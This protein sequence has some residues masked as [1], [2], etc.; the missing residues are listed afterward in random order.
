VLSAGDSLLMDGVVVRVLAPTA[1]WRKQQENPNESSVVLRVE[2]GRQ[3]WLLTGDAE[4]GAESWLLAHARGELA[5]SVLKV[6]HHGSRSSSTPEF[7]E[8]VSPRVAV[9]SVG[10][11]NDY[12][13]PSVEVLQ[14][15][16]AH[17]VHVLRTDDEGTMILSTD[18]HWLEVRTEW[19]RWR[20]SGG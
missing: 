19:G 14:R 4:A 5:A 1:D 20:Y 17:G 13:H 18:G 2:Y 7:I 9:V 15:L 3:R 6:G 10:R 11:D 12:G 16:D 8:A